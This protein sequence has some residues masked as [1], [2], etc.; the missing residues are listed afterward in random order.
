[1]NAAPGAVALAAALERRER[2]AG[3]VLRECLERI[4]GHEAE[5]QAFAHLDAA[6]AL[7]RAR[8][9]D[10]GS[11]AGPL[12]G[13]PIGVK[14]LLD[15]ADLPTAYGSPIWQGHRPRADAAVVSGCRAAGAVIPGK[16]VTTEFAA[17]T[18]GPTRNPHR[19]ERTPGGSSSG[20]AAAV[21]AGLLPL[22][23]G[24]QTAA[25]IVRPAAYCGVVGFK[26]TFGLVPRA[27]LKLQSDTLDTIGGFAASVEDVALLAAV[28]TGD[29]SM[30]AVA[31]DA[32]AARIGLFRGP[33][34]ESVGAD[35]QA[36]F[37]RV[38]RRI[39]DEVSAPP[40][41]A[42]LT[43]LQIDVM[44]HEAARNLAWER[45]QHP[46]QLSERLRTMLDAGASID[47][48][49]HR[50]HLDAIRDARRRA[51]A[52]FARHDLLLAPSAA[53][54]AGPIAEGTG[55]PLFGRAW[56]LLGLP[57]LHLPLGVGAGGLPIGL[58]LIGAAG[59]DA[60]L[61][62]AGAWLHQTLREV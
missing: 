7:A 15:T 12:H 13:L 2:R 24:T 51:D 10:A 21:A 36:L 62:Q 23:L 54:E 4:A 48:A 14:D 49:A 45:Q 1:M 60:R 8:Q 34:W 18:P 33:H 47:G 44:Q 32:S 11:V 43:A 22:A 58:Q 3:H 27:G 61:L 26:P 42:A 53:A 50:R 41:F 29:A 20:S 25:S 19:L 38:A 37:A 31:G 57:C 46:A 39:G 59:D 35:V 40:G 6:P 30:R 9:L 17:F 55:D 52:L 16:T 56:S 5:L 28:L